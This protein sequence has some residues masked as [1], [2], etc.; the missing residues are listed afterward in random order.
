MYTSSPSPVRRNPEPFG[1]TSSTPAIG[2]PSGSRS[3]FSRFSP[4]RFL[5]LVPRLGRVLGLGRLVGGLVVG[6]LAHIAALALENGLHQ[7]AP[8]HGPVALD[9]DLGRDRVEVGQGAVIELLAL[10]Y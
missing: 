9:A 2:S 10:Q 3:R 5:L 4:F 7:V 1:S 6:L 8:A